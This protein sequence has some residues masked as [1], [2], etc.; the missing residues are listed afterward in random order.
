MSAYGLHLHQPAPFSTA[1]NTCGRNGRYPPTFEPDTDRGRAR[2]R[3][4]A[5]GSAFNV[6]ASSPKSG[7][8]RL[9]ARTFIAPAFGQADRSCA[10][11]PPY[12]DRLLLN[13]PGTVF[14]GGLRRD[15]DCLAP[16]WPHIVPDPYRPPDKH[17][18]ES[19][20]DGLRGARQP[21]ADCAVNADSAGRS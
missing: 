10:T 8:S 14:Q 1:S 21:C 5:L 9:M 15:E 13:R 3:V 12:I 4:F 17:L 7:K 20:L 18:S 11:P 2:I 16:S 19:S 6:V